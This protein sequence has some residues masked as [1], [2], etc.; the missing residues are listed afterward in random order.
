MIKFG[1]KVQDKQNSNQ[2]DMF[3]DTAEASLQAPI[4]PNSNPW[5]TMKMLSKEKEVVGIYISGHPLDDY[6]FEIDNF[7]NGELSQLRSLDNLKGKEVAFAG[8]VSQCE[9]K[10]AKNGKPYGV[11]YLEDY[12]DNNR[13]F[14]F[15]DDYIKFKSFFYRRLAAL[16]KRKSTESPL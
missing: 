15:S 7:C 6:K 14:I 8:V 1:N 5:N 13:F 12:H 3:G 11:L 4:A 10:V 2:V 16:C 9:H